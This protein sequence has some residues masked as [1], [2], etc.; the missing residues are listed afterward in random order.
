[1]PVMPIT[2]TSPSNPFD[3]PGSEPAA[4]PPRVRARHAL[5]LPAGSVRAL[6]AF[7]VLGTLWCLVIFT[8][9]ETIPV[10]Y[11]YLQYVM[12]LILAHYFAAHGNT[13]S[14]G[15]SPEPSALGLPRGSVRFLLL[16]GFLGLVAYLFYHPRPVQA[17]PEAPM[18]LPLVLVS[19]FFAGYVVSKVVRAVSRGSLPYWFQ[20]IEA[21]IAL[22]A[23]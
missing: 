20:D 5:G 11:V 14:A 22:L 21:W 13:I 17:P 15:H 3:F 10:A 19:G 8:K 23:M 16:A 12:I 4:P 1:M 18:V 7:M 6:L 9:D 2:E